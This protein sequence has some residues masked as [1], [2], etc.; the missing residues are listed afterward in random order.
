MASHGMGG[1][2]K[3][4]KNANT[5][6]PG[7]PMATGSSSSV[8]KRTQ[9]DMQPPEWFD[10]A[11]TTCW[12]VVRKILMGRQQWTEENYLA[13]VAMCQCF[14]DWMSLRNFLAENGETYRVLAS[15]AG[16]VAR[17]LLTNDK[18]ADHEAQDALYI[19]RK[20]PQ[21]TMFSDVDRRFRS[22]LGEFGLTEASRRRVEIP[23]TPEEPD[24]ALTRYGLN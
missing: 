11:A 5:R 14:S 6:N 22:W 20:Y 2:P 12:N 4:S 17:R 13:L 9:A 10:H 19:L 24:A 23:P 7:N 3:G 15:G 1:R 8:V 18:Y 21:A 16:T